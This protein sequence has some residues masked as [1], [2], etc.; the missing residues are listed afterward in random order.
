MDPWRA[1]YQVP[2]PENRTYAD[3]LGIQDAQ[4]AP[5]QAPQQAEPYPA[6]PKKKGQ[7]AKRLKALRRK[8][9]L[10]EFAPR[11]PK[12]RKKSKRKT[13]GRLPVALKK[14]K[15]K[16]IYRRNVRRLGFAPTSKPIRLG[17]I[18]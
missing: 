12:K 8:Y 15:A 17:P 16:G 7:S 1:T 11:K 18:F 6:M 13:Y 10:G 9:K 5:Q 4:Q 14:V 3:A 2:M